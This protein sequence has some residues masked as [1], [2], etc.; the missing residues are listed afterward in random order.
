M[1]ERI[2]VMDGKK[3]RKG[4]EAKEGMFFSIDSYYYI[5]V[6]IYLHFSSIFIHS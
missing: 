4:K 5:H 1:R 3:R 6:C 2:K